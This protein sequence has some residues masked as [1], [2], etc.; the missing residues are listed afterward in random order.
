M[1]TLRI[2]AVVAC[3]AALFAVNVGCKKDSA[4]AGKAAVSSVKVPDEPDKAIMAGVEALKNNKPVEIYALLPKSYQKDI[5]DVVNVVT[6]NLDKEI[7]E[8][9][10]QV[11]DKSASALEKHGDKIAE[12]FGAGAPID[13]KVAFSGFQKF[14]KLMKE[15]KL[16]DYDAVKK[17]DVAGFLA[18]HGGKLMTEGMNA[19]KTFNAK[20]FEDYNK[21]ISNFSV[22]VKETQGDT[23]KVEI[24]VAGDTETVDLK[25]VEGVWVPKEM[26]EDWSEMIAEAKKEVEQ[27]M[28]EA[29]ANKEQAKQILQMALTAITQFESSGD[30][31][32]LQALMGGMM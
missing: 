17:L 18:Q 19:F 9:A 13:L 30:I 32:Q 4:E 21:V 23:A 2:V 27:G 20:D 22:K 29:M 3:C 8:L 24:S 16:T 14:Y 31:N 10:M 11:L 6:S 25:K 5:Q 28:K 26:A 7:F 1:K 15:A 12:K